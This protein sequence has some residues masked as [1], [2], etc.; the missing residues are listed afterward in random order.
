MKVNLSQ[1]IEGWKNLIIPSSDEKELINNVAQQRL[2][3]CAGC[4]WN[5]KNVKEVHLRPDE[6]CTKC[7]CT[8]APKV[9]CLS[10]KCPLDTPKWDEIIKK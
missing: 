6:R 3:I 9:R 5:S 7:G 10:C 4:E 8:L 2:F 1:I